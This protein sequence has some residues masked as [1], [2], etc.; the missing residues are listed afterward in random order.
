MKTNS[1]F[2]VLAA[3]ITAFGNPNPFEKRDPT[4]GD[5]VICG[6][7]TPVIVSV[8]LSVETSIT[9]TVPIVDTTVVVG[10]TLTAPDIVTTIGA[11]CGDAGCTCLLATVPTAIPISVTEPGTATVT[12]PDPLATTPITLTVTLPSI[13]FTG[14]L[15]V[16]TL[17]V[18]GLGVS[19]LVAVCYYALLTIPYR[20]ALL[21]SQARYPC[22][23]FEH[24]AENDIL[25]KP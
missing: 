4:C 21:R 6:L 13:G 15:P 2:V 23:W 10:A 11:G 18:S 16:P 14:E 3:A 24:T 8:P 7:S 25:F 20:S 22:F 5:N 1:F 17:P 19:T 9:V 12:I